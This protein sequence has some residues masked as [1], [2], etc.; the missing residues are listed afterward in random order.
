MQPHLD[1]GALK[2]V[3][4]AYRAAPL[5]VT[6]LYADRRRCAA[7]LRVF[8]KWLARLIGGAHPA[9]GERGRAG[10]QP[11]FCGISILTS[12]TSSVSRRSRWT[13]MS[14][15][16]ILTYLEITATSSFCSCGR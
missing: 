13:L 7:R 1:S 8:V 15:G 2:E 5:P 11:S 14:S 6:L 16:L 12:S 10:V 4:P 9:A 3:L